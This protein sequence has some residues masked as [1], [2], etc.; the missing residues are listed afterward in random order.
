MDYSQTLNLPKTDFPMRGNLPNREPEFLKFW[1]DINIY[2]K[3]QKKNEGKPKFILHDG[4]PYANGHL[5]LGHTL[6]KILKDIIV[7]FQSM[8]GYDA[9]YVPGWDTHGLPI[10]QQAIKQLGINRHEIDP[11]EFRRKCKEYALKFVDIQRDEFI[12]LGVRGDWKHPY[13]TLMPHFEARQ[14]GVFGEMAKR[15]YIYK[16]LKPVYWCASCETALAEAEVEYNDKTSPSVYVRFPVVE[17]YGLFPVEN[18]YVVIWTT[19]PWTIPANVAVSVHSEFQYVLVKVEESKYVVAKELLASFLDILGVQGSVIKEFTGA[20][21]E[22]VV[23]RHPIIER[24]SIVI[25]GDHVTLDQGTGCVH[26]AP[27]HGQEDFEV[28]KKYGLEVISPI[29]GKGIFTEEG[30]IFKGQFY[31]KANKSITE[32]LNSHGHL[33]HQSEIQHQFPHCWRCKNPVFFRATEQWFAS[34]EGFRQEALNEIRKVRWIPAWGEDRIYN[35]VEGRGDWCISRQ[36][37]WGVPIP[38]FYCNKCGKELITDETIKHLQGLFK[39]YGSDVWFAREADDLL[40]KGTK[41]SDCGSTD[42]SK[43]T[44]IMD[45]WFDSGSSHQGVLDEKDVWP[46]LSWPADL[47]LEGSDQHRGWFNSSLS[48]SV[49]VTG[50]APYRAVLTH[51]FVVDEKGRKMSKSLGN[52][53]DPQKVIKQLGADILRLWVSSADYKGDLAVSQ[54]ILKQMTESYRKIRNTCRFLLGNL[55]DFNL[56]VDQVPYEKMNELDRWALLKLHRLIERVLKA[57]RDYEFHVVYHAIHNF[58]TVDM[59]NRYLDIIKDRLYTAP[60]ASTERRAAQTVLYKILDALVRLLTPV[61][62]FTSE[63]IWQHMPKTED[64][65]KSVQLLDMPEPEEKYLDVDLEEKWKQIMNVR[66]EVI[67]ILEGARRQK[68][69]GNSLEAKVVLYLEKDLFEF[70]NPLK[71]ELATIFIVS[72]V[73]LVSGHDNL[74]ENAIRSETIPELTV[75]VSRMSGEKCERCW[76]YHEEVGVD[77]EHPGLCPRC[78]GVVKAL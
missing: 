3:V 7:K 38:I 59:S 6:N 31:L 57:Y 44:D 64:M 76:M 42:F 52:V 1:E 43:E 50:K 4:P 70:L 5:H 27:G 60:T 33:L 10:E 36:R 29:N 61:L 73:D 20:E 23:L 34:I 54:N 11:V 21:L 65:P 46:E 62:A 14:I 68:V 35:M 47:Y 32:E 26:T 30:G 12:R 55:N 18:T 51:G 9:P 8:S 41:C 24:E 56:T 39:E 77:E 53:V 71:D 72:A 22:N 2:R 75:A 15:G 69:I 78:A 19:T 37:T 13:V 25:L 40:P 16:G 48:T 28:G 74:P 17:S 45:V 49:A 63:E 58:C 66:N 67:R